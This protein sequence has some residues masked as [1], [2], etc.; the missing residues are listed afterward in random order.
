MDL[1]PRATGS[2][3]NTANWTQYPLIKCSLSLLSHSGT[4]RAPFGACRRLRS[5]NGQARSNPSTPDSHHYFRLADD[6]EIEYREGR[7]LVLICRRQVFDLVLAMHI[8]GRSGPNERSPLQKRS[9]DIFNRYA[10][11]AVYGSASTEELAGLFEYPEL[12]SISFTHEESEIAYR[13][14][15]G[16]GR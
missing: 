10:N 15:Q 5:D 2:C 6:P 3:L 4:L 16:S 1:L 8:L 9:E 12:E 11:R 14:L 7:F 13:A